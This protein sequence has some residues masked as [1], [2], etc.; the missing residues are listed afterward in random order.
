[1]ASNRGR[2]MK[3]I[4]LTT[5]EGP[6]FINPAFV[7]AVKRGIRD[8]AVQTTS[9]AY[10]VKESVEVAVRLLG[11]DEVPRDITLPTIEG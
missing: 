9:A 5:D 10:I 6:V 4:R 2:P 11:A 7:V 1:M 3:L 8:T